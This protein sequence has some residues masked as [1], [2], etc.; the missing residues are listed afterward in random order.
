MSSPT[1]TV[2]LVLVEEPPDPSTGKGGGR[3]WK[4][5]RLPPFP[6][7]QSQGAVGYAHYDPSKDL[8]FSQRTWRNGALTQIYNPDGSSEGRYLQADGIDNRWDG[9]SVL[10]MAKSVQLNI[11]LPNPGFELGTASGWTLTAGS[12]GGSAAIN[13]TAPIA[14]RTG[15]Y[16]ADIRQTTSGTTSKLDYTEPNYLALAGRT[17]TLGAWVQMEGSTSLQG[18][19]RINDGVSTTTAVCGQ[20]LGSYGFYSVTKTLDATPTTLVLSVWTAASG[21]NPCSLAIDDMVF[22]VNTSDTVVGAAEAKGKLCIAVGPLILRWNETNTYW[23]LIY[24]QVA[25]TAAT[26]IISHNDILYVAF[27][28]STAY[29]YSADVSVASPTFTVSTLAGNSKYAKYW[30]IRRNQIWKSETAYQVTNTTNAQNGGVAWASLFDVGS[31]STDITKL[32]SFQDS[33]V[34]GKEDGLHFFLNVYEDGTTASLFLNVT[35]QFKTLIDTD[36]FSRGFEIWGKLY[37][38]AAQQSLFYFDGKSLVNI[39][40]L[41]F[42]PRSGHT[43]RVRAIT[44]DPSNLFMLV[45]TNTADTSSTKTTWLYSLQEHS[46]RWYVHTLSKVD[47][48]DIN[49]IT[50]Y[51]G[52]L[53]AFGRLNNSGISDYQISTFRWTLPTKSVAPA[54]DATPAIGTTGNFDTFVWDGGLPDEQKAFIALTL[55][56]KPSTLDANHTII[57]KYGLDGASSTTTTLGTFSGTGAIQT[58]FFDTVTTPE[59]NAIGRS[60]QL[61]FAYASNNTVSPELYAFALH[62]TLRPARVRTWE[63]LVYIGDG[64]IQ[65]NGMVDPISKTTLMA[66]IRTLEAQVYPIRLTADLDNSGDASTS[67]PLYQQAVQLVPGSLERVSTEERVNGVE[68]WRLLLQ[69]VT[70]S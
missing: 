37:L 62:S 38:I 61:N 11:V 10:G 65:H 19:I 32:Y 2:E 53:Y 17:I 36:N 54:Y 6:P 41:L 39:S 28:Y 59:T 51:S 56:V 40:A 12:N 24:A 30:A 7:R 69:E 23:E 14:P 21:A 5:S 50:V 66:N 29:A 44:G 26:D 31:Q 16:K 9:T 35:N 52:Y 46:G 15:S 68:V 13:G 64:V 18:T 34:V 45:D 8:V 42:T 58:K 20:T 70:V 43:G 1:T 4:E 55:F 33:I 27:G 25:G 63:A 49:F 60:V 47:I 57:V 22:Y 67:A 3:K 48:G